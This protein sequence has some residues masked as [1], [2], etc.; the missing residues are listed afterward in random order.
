MLTRRMVLCCTSWAGARAP[1]PVLSACPCVAGV[2][3]AMTDGQADPARR[4][5]AGPAQKLLRRRRFR[6][7]AR[8]RSRVSGYAAPRAR[9]A[10]APLHRA[11][12]IRW[13]CACSAEVAATGGR[14]AE[15]GPCVAAA[16]WHCGAWDAN[17][18]HVD[19]Q[20]VGDYSMQRIIRKRA[21]FQYQ[22]GQRAA[23]TACV[24]RTSYAVYRMPQPRWSPYTAHDV[25]E[26]HEC[27]TARA[28]AR[29]ARCAGF[30]RGHAEARA[31]A[32]I[33][34]GA[35]SRRLQRRDV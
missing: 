12:C 16:V 13:S 17:A 27:Y 11:A 21:R 24:W 14:C 23:Y 3:S 6:A 30:G 10:R 1:L 5:C 2:Y 29:T 8:L 35:C 28:A 33:R 20:R 4:C 15:P 7:C 34:S 18:A 32:G 19:R 25:L 31:A 26:R 9:S 22:K